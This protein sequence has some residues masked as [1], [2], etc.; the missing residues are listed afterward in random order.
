MNR[1]TQRKN[2]TVHE[3]LCLVRNQCKNGC[4]C[5]LLREENIDVVSQKKWCIFSKFDML[6]DK[7]ILFILQKVK[8]IQNGG[9]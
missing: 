2:M 3:F 9:R 4:E 5:C 7:S 6:S 1:T 8:N